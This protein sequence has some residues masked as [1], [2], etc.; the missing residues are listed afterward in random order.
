MTTDIKATQL[1]RVMCCGRELDLLLWDQCGYWDLGISIPDWFTPAEVEIA[2]AQAQLA[3]PAAMRYE[4]VNGEQTNATTYH[5]TYRIIDD[6]N[7]W[8]KPWEVG[9]QTTSPRAA[10]RYVQE[11]FTEMS[12]LHSGTM[13]ALIHYATTGQAV[14][15][16]WYPDNA[17]YGYRTVAGQKRQRVELYKRLGD[18]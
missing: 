6:A 14:L 1:S 15:A 4:I 12:R 7:P 16:R 3:K 18:F 11:R 2:K 13:E 9:L 5:C 17:K 10:E 8:V